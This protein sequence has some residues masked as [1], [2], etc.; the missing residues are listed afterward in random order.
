MS[1]Y[2]QVSLC[3]VFNVTGSKI[4]CLGTATARGRKIDVEKR[5]F[6]LVSGYHLNSVRQIEKMCHIHFNFLPSSVFFAIKD[7]R[8][9]DFLHVSDLQAAS[10]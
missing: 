8:F 10:F 4:S 1:G 6:I 5:F 7:S 9:K 2:R 3:V